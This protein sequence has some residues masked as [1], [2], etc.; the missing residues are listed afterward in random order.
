[1]TEHYAR[2]FDPELFPQLRS[3]RVAQLV[4]MPD[5]LLPPQS[6]F[7][8][9]FVLKTRHFLVSQMFRFAISQGLPKF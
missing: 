3:S 7:S 6:T 5:V 8:S 1:V 2:G 4:G 9:A